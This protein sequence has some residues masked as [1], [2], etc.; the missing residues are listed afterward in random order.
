[1]AGMLWRHRLKIGRKDTLW[2]TV[3]HNLYRRDEKQEEAAWWKRR[4]V[5]GITWSCMQMTSERT[6]QS[7]TVWTRRR[8]RYA[9]ANK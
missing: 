3:S 6:G 8:L 4:D 5:V 7:N 2:F 9:F 1:M